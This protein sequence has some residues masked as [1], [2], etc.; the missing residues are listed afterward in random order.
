MNFGNDPGRL[1]DYEFRAMDYQR[2]STGD[3]YSGNLANHVLRSFWG[4]L[5]RIALALVVIFVFLFLLLFVVTLM[6]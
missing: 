5:W 6:A 2:R 4:K 1:Q 3:Y